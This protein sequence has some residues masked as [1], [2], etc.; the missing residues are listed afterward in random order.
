MKKFQIFAIRTNGYQRDAKIRIDGAREIYDVYY[1]NPESYYEKNTVIDKEIEVEGNLKI[2]WV[3]DALHTDQSLSFRQPDY[4]SS[5]TTAVVE[6]K[7]IIE[8]SRVMVAT[9]EFSWDIPVVFE[10]AMT[11]TIGQKILIS[12]FL[13]IEF[14]DD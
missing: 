1:V 8:D 2:I 9:S 10:T 3:L 4:N 12:G 6:I 11:L 14:E 5:F 13:A 7:N